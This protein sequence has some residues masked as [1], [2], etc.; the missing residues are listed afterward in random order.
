MNSTT[1]LLLSLVMLTL[2]GAFVF[3]RIEAPAEVQTRVRATKARQR[4]F[5]LAQELAEEGEKADWSKLVVQVNKYRDKLRQAWK[6]GNDELGNTVIPPLWSMW[7]SIYYC[8]TLFSTIGYG[9]VYPNTTI[10]RVL[11]I[12]YCLLAIPLCTLVFSRISKIIVRFLKAINLMTIE[13]SGIPVGL[14]DAYA[15][16]DTNF[17]FSLLTCMALLVGYFSLSG[18]IYCWGIGPTAAEWSPFDAVYFS[19]ISMTS[20]GLGDIVPTSETF[21]NLASLLYIL[22]GLILTNLVFTRMVELMEAKLEAIS[23]PEATLVTKSIPNRFLKD[24]VK[25]QALA[26]P[27]DTNTMT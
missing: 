26:G 23:A 25:R 24:S 21:L 18:V 22:F 7:G 5:V 19:F 2:L 13:S 10:G 20:V 3:T 12:G 27:G 16:A 15:R 4:I 8:I 14:R 11:T 17:D 9:N 6:A 1:G